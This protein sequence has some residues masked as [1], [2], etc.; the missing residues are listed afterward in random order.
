MSRTRSKNRNDASPSGGEKIS[1]DT[2]ID[3]A[4]HHGGENLSQREASNAASE[5]EN[6]LVSPGEPAREEPPPDLSGEQLH[7]QAEQLAEYLRQ[8]QKELDHRESQLNAQSAQLESDARTARIWLGEREAD[9]QERD[10]K[11]TALQAELKQRLERLAAAEAAI[12]QR[13]KQSGRSG[14]ND[15]GQALADISSQ[16]GVQSQQLSFQSA[17]LARLSA[18]LQS[19]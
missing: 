1:L 13:S 16:W 6:A 17:D 2:R 11:R 18:D 15:I 14:E 9:L 7:R 3:P 4:H 8:R 12:E 10:A 5:A 19:K